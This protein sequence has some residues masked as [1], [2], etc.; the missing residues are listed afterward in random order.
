M[1]VVVFKDYENTDDDSILKGCYKRALA[2]IQTSI[3]YVSSYLPPKK[4][5]HE[6]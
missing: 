5:N 2:S 6:A 3:I 4:D 1:E